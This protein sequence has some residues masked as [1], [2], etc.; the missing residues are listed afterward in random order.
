MDY[1]IKA[2]IIDTLAK[3][4]ILFQQV[5]TAVPVTFPAHVSILTGLS[6]FSWCSTS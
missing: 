5:Y 2:P 1:L 3:E 4:G 6:S